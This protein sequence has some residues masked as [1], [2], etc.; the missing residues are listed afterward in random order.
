MK[1]IWKIVYYYDIVPLY[2]VSKEQAQNN[3]GIGVMFSTLASTPFL[4][5]VFTTSISILHKMPFLIYM[6]KK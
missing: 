3:D 2:Y 4:S 5:Y 1:Y 6:Y